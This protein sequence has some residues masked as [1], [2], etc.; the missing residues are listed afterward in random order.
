MQAN[1]T[2]KNHFIQR[3]L[4]S[5]ITPDFYIQ[6]VQEPLTKAIRYT[7]LFSLL[8]SI[9]GGIYFSLEVKQTFTYMDAFISDPHFPDVIITDGKL[10]LDSNNDTELVIGGNKNFIAIIDSGDKKNYTYL[11]GYK[12]GIFM[13]SDY[14]AFKKANAESFVVKFSQLSNLRL[15]KSSFQR[16]IGIAEIISY[17]FTF[18]FYF[19]RVIFQYF[20]KALIVYALL[21]F[22]FPILR[23]RELNLKSSQIFT[24]ILYAMSFATFASELFNFMSISNQWILSAIVIFFYMVTLRIARTGILA[25]LLNKLGGKLPPVGDDDP[26]NQL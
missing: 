26:W 24:V 6:A 23:V 12:Y 15:S 2:P 3:F 7:L 25:I 16:A 19:L 21:S 22:T 1:S 8:L 5:F 13:N 18:L 10:A 20:I 11:N 14:I 9:L 17:I 4:A